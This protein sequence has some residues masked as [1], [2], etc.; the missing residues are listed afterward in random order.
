MVTTDTINNDTGKERNLCLIKKRLKKLT[1]ASIVPLHYII[2]FLVSSLIE[3]QMT[4]DGY[5][6]LYLL[7]AVC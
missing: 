5:P 3:F 6:R 4:K 7:F 2:I 1:T